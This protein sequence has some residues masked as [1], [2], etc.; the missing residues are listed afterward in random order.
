MAISFLEPDQVR[1]GDLEGAA[2][3]GG[4]GTSR[5]GARRAGWRG[6][7]W[8]PAC[9]WVG[10]RQLGEFSFIVCAVVLSWRAHCVAHLA[11]LC[12][13]LPLSRAPLSPLL[14]RHPWQS[15]AGGR[16][17]GGRGGSVCAAGRAGGAGRRQEEQGGR[18]DG[19]QGGS[20]EEELEGASGPSLACPLTGGGLAAATAVAAPVGW[21]LRTFKP[22]R[23]LDRFLYDSTPH[24][25]LVSR[26]PIPAFRAAHSTKNNIPC[27]LP[28]FMFC[29]SAP[30]PV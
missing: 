5:C 23:Q 1:N 3:A 7:D 11:R 16:G 15:A 14:Q 26:P 21:R 27:T 25:P 9:L 28:R 29:Y 12:L 24:H 8:V 19:Q 22:A 30:Q 2:S 13:T 18:G 20:K 17:G 10:G 4:R 6:G